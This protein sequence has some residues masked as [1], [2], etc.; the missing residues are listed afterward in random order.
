M[1]RRAPRRLVPPRKML[2]ARAVANEQ[3]IDDYDGE[4][5]PNMKLSH[6]FFVVLVLHVLAVGGVFAFNTLKTHQSTPDRASKAAAVAKPKAK[7]Q[8]ETSKTATVQSNEAP[9]PAPQP[10]QATKPLVTSATYTV[11]AGDTLTSIAAKHKTT[12]EAL[13]KANGLASDSTLH[14]GQVL[15]LPSISGGKTVA[16][17]APKPAASVAP[18]NAPVS[19][20]A[21][22]VKASSGDSPKATTSTVSKEDAKKSTS[23]SKVY[24]VVKG[25]NPYSIAKK[26]KVNYNELIKVNK[27]ED[28]TKLQI[29]QK[30]VIP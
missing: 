29:G 1:P 26:L 25:D 12:I 23:S 28:P 4:A 6:A 5:E 13:E 2:H 14:V 15:N 20:K 10:S 3:E 18:P 8:V 27:I 24:V 19:T 30:L 7:P 17:S 9:K 16:A 11:V 22:Q 21:S